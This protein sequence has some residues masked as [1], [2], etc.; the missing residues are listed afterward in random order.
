MK[1]LFIDTN[2]VIDFIINTIRACRTDLAG[3][4]FVYARLKGLKRPQ[5]RDYSKQ[6]IEFE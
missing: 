2:I 3:F 5:N 6:I 4:N 1:R